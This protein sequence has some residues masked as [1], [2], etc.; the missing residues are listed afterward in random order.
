MNGRQKKMT[1]WI[2]FM[3]LVLTV[4]GVLSFLAHPSFGHLP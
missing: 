1:L 2:L 3:I 4:T